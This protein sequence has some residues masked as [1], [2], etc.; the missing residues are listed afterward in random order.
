MITIPAVVT[1]DDTSHLTAD[2]TLTVDGVTIP[3]PARVPNPLGGDGTTPLA[4]H[5]ILAALTE[6]GYRPATR[7]WRH[8]DALRGTSGL[9]FLVT[10]L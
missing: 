10:P 6:L 8:E 9:A 7:T 3:I 2:S 4:P 5:R 1:T